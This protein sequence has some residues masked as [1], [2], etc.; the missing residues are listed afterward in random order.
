MQV[1][2]LDESMPAAYCE[3]EMDQKEY[4]LAA[5]M[6]TDIVGFSR[7]MERDEAGTLDLLSTHNKLVRDTVAAHNGRVIRTIGDAFLCEFSNTV[8]AVKCAAEIQ[9]AAA[10]HN[11]DDPRLPLHLRI[12]VHL[13]DIYFL[14]DDAVGDGINV[15][16][17]LQSVG[18]P[19]RVTVSRDVYHLVVNKVPYAM[20]SLGK[21]RL[22]D[23]SR[24][25][26]A[27]E[28]AI[29]PLAEERESSD[30]TRAPRAP[31]ATP[32]A[33]GGD[34]ADPPEAG[35]SD[36]GTRRGP[37]QVIAENLRRPEY[38]DF[39]ELKALVLQEIKRA[40][41]RISID[42]IRDRIP[43]RGAGVDGALESLAEKGFLTRVRREGGRTDYGPVNRGVEITTP[44]GRTIFDEHGNRVGRDPER[45]RR[46]RQRHDEDDW[47]DKWDKHEWRGDEKQHRREQSGWDRA[48]REPAP[49]SAYD[50][51]VEDYRDHAANV[52]EKEKSGFRGH[53]ISY[54]SVNGG[55][56]F[57]WAMTSFGGFPW[58]L[59]P[60]LAWGIGIASHYVG[61][62]DRVQESHELDAAEGLT[63]EQLRI[64][65]K[66]AKNRGAWRGHLVSNAATSVFL[67]VLN[68]I[69][70]P[71]FMWSLFPVAFMGIGVLSHL[72]AY[73]SRERRLLKRLRD[74]GARI[75]GALGGKGSVGRGT[76]GGR[77]E[78]ASGPGAEAEQIRSRLI[79][80]I[81]AMPSGSPLGDDFEP[82]LDNYVEQVKLLDQKNR[83][84]DEIMRGIPLADLQRDLVALQKRRQEAQSEKVIA[85]Y[86]RS[87]TQ[88][89][90]QQSSYAELRNEQ[91]IMRLRL[92]SSLNQL[93]QLEIDVARMKS[94][95]S[96][97]E[98]ISVAMLKDKSR[99]MSQYLDD[100]RAGYRELE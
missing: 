46:S 55:L 72:P 84:L 18:K 20:R 81:K 47:S 12:G 96:E 60:L 66:L 53:L 56:F 24:E 58:F 28:I 1:L 78:P 90:K 73:R 40:G 79:G 21:V 23:I 63:R 41:R 77:Q 51:L 49:A 57:I 67:V 39:N 4:R 31:A 13:G 27:Y 64:Y 92:S 54:A 91:E 22:R 76:E 26:D 75:G 69:T 34:S 97:E 36:A 80:S 9:E 15:V 65:R 61:V 48:L 37:G 43:N 71:G 7:M 25:I 38:A 14:E 3:P 44:G 74:L 32:P 8:N 17:R 68:L 82:V 95:S 29:S 85:E 11:E 98:S 50:S 89:Q 19:G 93:K 6:F 5:V 59:I 42:E 87:I 83:E 35:A 99:E 2:C 70:S 88:I 16:T 100:L 52:A 10:I 30:D 86:D 62:K 94:V 33:S 45:P